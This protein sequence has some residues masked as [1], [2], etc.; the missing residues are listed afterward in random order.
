MAHGVFIAVYEHPI[1]RAYKNVTHILSQIHTASNG[2]PE[3]ETCKCCVFPAILNIWP[4]ILRT[5]FSLYSCH[6]Y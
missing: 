4:V 6:E 1:S 2:K 5:I 3:A